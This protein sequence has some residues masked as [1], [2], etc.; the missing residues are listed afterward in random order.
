LSTNGFV[1]P[2]LLEGFVHCE[3]HGACLEENYIPF[4]RGMPF[5]LKDVF[6]QQAGVRP[7]T[8]NTALEILNCYFHHRV[9]GNSY[10]SQ[11]EAGSSWPSFYPDIIL[12]HHFCED[13]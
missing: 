12:C 2:V 9:L 5:D 4:L 10:P 7:L 11:F 8:G 13:L 3:G 6:F 1:K